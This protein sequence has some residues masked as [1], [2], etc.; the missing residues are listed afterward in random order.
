MV[1]GALLGK[2]GVY[3]LCCTTH[4]VIFSVALLLLRLWETHDYNR[5]FRSLQDLSSFAHSS[6]F[7]SIGR[8]KAFL[9]SP[10]FNARSFILF[11]PVPL[12]DLHF[13]YYCRSKMM[14]TTKMSTCPKMKRRKRS[15]RASSRRVELD[16]FVSWSESHW[17]GLDRCGPEL[18]N[19]TLELISSFGLGVSLFWINQLR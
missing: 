14:M 9:N 17:L 2:V 6:P 11:A 12:Y 1:T 16:L 19:L 13:S 10:R 18:P 15:E 5:C 7:L 4:I 8:E 3:R